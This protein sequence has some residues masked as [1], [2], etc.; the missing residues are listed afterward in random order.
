VKK[1]DKNGQV[2]DDDIRRRMRFASG[3]S[4]TTHIH[5]ESVILSRQNYTKLHPRLS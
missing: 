1:Y 4:K 2:T 5:S 3:I